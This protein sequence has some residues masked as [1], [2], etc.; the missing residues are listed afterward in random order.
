MPYLYTSIENKFLTENLNK[1]IA[2][3]SRFQQFF[4]ISFSLKRRKF[5]YTKIK[6]T[7]EENPP[8]TSTSRAL[9]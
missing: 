6:A 7:Q 5:T 3:L 8:K 9:T 4:F 2:Y 1:V